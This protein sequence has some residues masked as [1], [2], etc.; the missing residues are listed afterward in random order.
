MNTALRFAVVA[1]A[2]AA[3]A[4]TVDAQTATANAASMTIADAPAPSAATAAASDDVE[5]G[6]QILA[7]W[8]VGRRVSYGA[9]RKY[10]MEKCFSAE[11]VDSRIRER[12]Y[13]RSY[14]A[15]CTIAWADLRYLRL[16]HYDAGGHIV[17]GEMVCHKDVAA[18]LVQIFRALFDARYPIE[19]MRLIDDYDADDARS[20]SH[21]N[22]TCFNYRVVA[23]SKK[24]SNHS[25]G[26]AVDLNPLYNPY[27][28]RRADGTLLVNPESGRRYA[29]R[30]R[31]FAY[32]IDR[33]DLAYR[34][35]TKHGFVWGGGWKSLKDYQ[36]FEK[37]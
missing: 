28:R 33:N 5:A 9:V 11:S 15:E 34:L 8:I 18:D 30:S 12:M 25:R 4:A 26:K 36:H 14:K 22:T 37:K 31:P 13:G 35:F 23:G 7:A 3:I 19:R 24:L 10:G 6:R 32:K 20:M 16:L 17:L 1:T 27:V 2:F 29:D 21:N